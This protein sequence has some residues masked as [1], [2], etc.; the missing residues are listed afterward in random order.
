VTA[1]GAIVAQKA[2]SLFSS[3]LDF[4]YPRACRGCGDTAPDAGV[5]LCWDCLASI[6]TISRPYC[7]RCGDPAEGVID[8]QYVCTLCRRFDPP[9]DLARSAVRYRGIIRRILH[10][11]K[12]GED[13]CMTN[14][15]VNM[16]DACAKAHFSRLRF[17]A[18]M[19][20]PLHARRERERTYNQSRLLAGGLARRLRVPMATTRCIV[21]RRETASQTGLNADG[22]RAN[23]RGAFSVRDADWLQG[24]TIL[25]VDDV[26][27]TGAT[28]AECA[29]TIKDAGAAAV[30]VV[31]VAR[32]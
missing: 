29:G 20:V 28:V 13:V 19:G 6:P 12:Y 31:T 27:T 15:L 4:V 1:L 32:G 17:D 3:T 24:R 25:L 8:H 2:L 16:L 18:V 21:R 22:R 23:V 30:Y 10:G 7:S 11:F 9:F 5:Y 26:M 14:D